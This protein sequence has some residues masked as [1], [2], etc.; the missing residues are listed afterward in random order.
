MIDVAALATELVAIPSVSGDEAALAH[1]VATLLEE[2]PHLEL[3]RIGDNVVARTSLQ[4]TTRMI[5]AGHLDTVAG[6]ATARRR[7]CSL[8]SFLIGS[9]RKWLWPADALR[10]V[11]A[12]HLRP[13]RPTP[14][15][16]RRPGSA[17]PAPTSW[18]WS[19]P[20]GLTKRTLG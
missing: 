11:E 7:R 8:F 12:G 4:R 18:P 10:V 19:A 17:T 1:R 15:R 5:V 16:R 14:A 9:R 2:A 6:T 13:A 20:G 3:I